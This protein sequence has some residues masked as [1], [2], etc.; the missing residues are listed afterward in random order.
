LKLSWRD[1]FVMAWELTWPLAVLDVLFVLLTH[2]LFSVQGEAWDSGWAVVSFFVV[3]PFVIRRALERPYS[4][5]RI[6]VVRSTGVAKSLSYQESLKVTWLFAWR[7][8]ILSFAALILI[9]FLLRAAVH[10]SYNFS[11]QDPMV[12]SLGLSAVDVLSSLAFTPL[13]IPG[14]IRKRFKGFHLE[15]RSGTMG[16]K[17]TDS[18]V[19]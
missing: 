10:T 14:L 16:N 2:G 3:S 18:S 9:S 4:G 1:R 17:R 15:V 11:T 12:N 7:T 5:L 13:L 6:F 19:H 8:L